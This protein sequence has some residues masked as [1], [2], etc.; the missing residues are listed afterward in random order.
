MNKSD[1]SLI[2][3]II[4]FSIIILLSIVFNKSNG[5]KIAKVYYENEL[6]LSI[7]L[8]DS[9]SKTFSV[10]GYNGD[11]IIKVDGNKIMVE[12]ENSPL[13]LCSKQGW[14]KETYETIVCLPNKIIIVIEASTE[15]DAVVK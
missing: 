10:K 1:I 12:E 2:I 15:L 3:F 14:I 4:V 6:L 9:K 13:N 8:M 5:E 7:P 11:V